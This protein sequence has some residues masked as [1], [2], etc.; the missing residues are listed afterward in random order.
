MNKD[1]YQYILSKLSLSMFPTGFYCMYSK[2]NICICFTKAYFDFLIEHLMKIV[3]DT[4]LDVEF[5]GCHKTICPKEES[6]KKQKKC[7]NCDG[8]KKLSCLR[9]PYL[10]VKSDASVEKK[11]TQ[12]YPN[13]KYSVLHFQDLKHIIAI[14]RDIESECRHNENL[15]RSVVL[16]LINFLNDGQ[17][18]IHGKNKE[19]LSS[20]KV[21]IKQLDKDL[22]LPK[23]FK[24]GF[25]DLLNKEE[26]K[27]SLKEHTT[28]LEDLS[29]GVFLKIINIWFNEK[30]DKSRT[31]ENTF[32]FFLRQTIR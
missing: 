9:E 10:I 2:T 11:L 7:G 26:K 25:S 15:K 4:N 28:D 21:A 24:K 5:D 32:D 23:P 31:E 14:L 30:A 16:L 12:T 13:S 27:L 6:C 19:R 1:E 3:K 29:Y 20:F 18:E 17:V 8:K 22:S